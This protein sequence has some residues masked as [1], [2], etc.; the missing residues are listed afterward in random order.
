M[1]SHLSVLFKLIPAS[2][3]YT[4]TILQQRTGLSER[5]VGVNCPAAEVINS[6]LRCEHALQSLGLTLHNLN[7][8]SADRPA[9]CYW[10]SG[11]SKWGFFNK[12]FDPLSTNPNK[13]GKRGGVCT[14]VGKNCS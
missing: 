12:F 8:D 7:V 10:L 14:T 6:K 11:G 9:G 2:R 4:N 1:I 3:L 5:K 13:F